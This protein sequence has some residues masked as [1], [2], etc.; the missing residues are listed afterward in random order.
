MLQKM[1]YKVE[2]PC[3]R[4][5]KQELDELIREK[6]EKWRCLTIAPPSLMEAVV[7]TKSVSDPQF[8]Y[9]YSIL[10]LDSRDPYI[11]KIRPFLKY[12]FDVIGPSNGWLKEK[13]LTISIPASE[14]VLLENTG[15]FSA[16]EEVLATRVLRDL[17]KLR[18][19][20]CVIVGNASSLRAYRVEDY[21]PCQPSDTSVDVDPRY[22][23]PALEL[24]TIDNYCVDDV[25]YF[26][27]G[28]I[29]EK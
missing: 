29:K 11:S 23:M 9:V 2:C 16:E 12:C 22:V 18:E 8:V 27:E 1:R 4:N 7:V 21:M 26:A 5:T 14:G 17:T 6:L 15:N 28:F 13:A 20:G 10:S 3:I 19:L 24:G 25:E